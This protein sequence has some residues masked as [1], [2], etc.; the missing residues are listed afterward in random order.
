MIGLGLG[1]FGAMA[2][3]AFSALLST[4][5]WARPL[6]FAGENSI[7]VYLAFFLP[8][9]VTRTVLLHL[10]PEIDVGL[11]AVTV[12]AVG[13]ITPLIF[14]VLVRRTPLMFLF[15]RPAWARLGAKHE[16]EKPALAGAD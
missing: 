14:F 4:W 5:N 3:V 8:M 7:V 2:V 6:R 13:A 15:R 11:A 16:G 12:T 10:T 9:A 1:F